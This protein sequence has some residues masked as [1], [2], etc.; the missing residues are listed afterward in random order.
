MAWMIDD[1]L[2]VSK[3]EAGE[4][5]LNVTT[6][7]LAAVLAEKQVTYRARLEAEGKVLAIQAPADLPAIM[8]DAELI[9]RVLDN[10]VD[11]A[12]KYSPPGGH[13]EISAEARDQ[14]V[15][16]DVRDDGEGILPDDRDRIFD[17]F[18]QGSAAGAR[19]ARHGAG[20]GLAFCRLAV[21]AHGGTIMATSEPGHGATFTVTLPIGR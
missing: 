8:A 7:S 19:P 1:L 2:N 11:N 10:L 12:I 4:L 13:I 9:G 15:K 17:K 14:A 20:L 21:V 5:R 18:V 16:I 6:I 3:L